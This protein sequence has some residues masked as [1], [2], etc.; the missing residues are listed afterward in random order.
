MGR[1]NLEGLQRQR[2]PF[3]PLR[4]RQ[5]HRDLSEAAGKDDTLEALVKGILRG[6]RYEDLYTV[7]RHIAEERGIEL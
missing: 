5:M 7:A 4:P 6:Q 3:F 2:R 1:T